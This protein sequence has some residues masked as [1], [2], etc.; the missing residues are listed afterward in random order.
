MG[1]GRRVVAHQLFAPRTQDRIPPGSLYYQ[2]SLSRSVLPQ[3]RTKSRPVRPTPTPPLRS[4]SIST[5]P[6]NYKTILF[7]RADHPQLVQLAQLT[8]I[9]PRNLSPPDLIDSFLKSVDI[10]SSPSD[11]PFRHDRHLNLISALSQSSS[12]LVTKLSEPLLDPTFPLRSL[13]SPRSFTDPASSF[14]RLANTNPEFFRRIIENNTGHILDIAISTAVNSIRVVPEVLSEPRCLDFGRATPNWVVLL[15]AIADVK[16][17][18]TQNSDEFNSIRASHLTFLILSTASTNNELSTAAVSVFSNQFG[19]S[20]P[21]TEALLF[22][23]PFDNQNHILLAHHQPTLPNHH[24]RPHLPNRHS[25]P[26]LPNRHSRPLLPNHH[27]RPHLPNHHSRPHLPNRHSRRFSPIVTLA[28]FS[29][30]VTRPLLPNRHSRPLLPNRHSRPLLPNHHS[31]HFSPIVTLARFSPIVT[32]ARFSRIITLARISRIITLARFSRIIT[33]ARFSP[34]VTL[35]R[36][37]PIVTLARFSP[38]VTL[39]RFSP[40]VTLARF[41]PI[42]TLARFSP[43]VTLARFS[44]IV[45]LA[46]FSPIVTLARFSPIVTLARFSPIV[47]LARFSRIVTLARIST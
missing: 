37:S 16:M 7:D 22:T 17:D 13:L 31:R 27:S 19:Q 42:V 25:R 18:L 20:T 28:R 1:S 10:S 32:L 5:N 24:S 15:N 38:I 14:L 12:P 46:R 39:A 26:L 29:P 43:I 40:I 11:T 30:I 36:F 44:P 2:E 33:L 8:L 45:T 41:S 4:D 47:T 35:A 6:N 34:I 23:P 3:H 9:C 21:H